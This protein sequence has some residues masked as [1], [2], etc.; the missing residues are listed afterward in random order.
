MEFDIQ[1]NFL[2]DCKENILFTFGFFFSLSLLAMERKMVR[3]VSKMIHLSI[4][5]SKYIPTWNI[6]D[7]I[8]VRIS[9]QYNISSIDEIFFEMKVVRDVF[10][11]S[12]EYVGLLKKYPLEDQL[13][14]RERLFMHQRIS[15]LHGVEINKWRN[16]IHEVKWQ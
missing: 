12:E 2:F 14:N 7:I 4:Q 11:R 13:N 5:I 9:Y 1:C 16:S 15:L 3:R 8:F 10:I 6:L